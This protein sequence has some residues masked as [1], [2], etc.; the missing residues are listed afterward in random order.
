MAVLR[1]MQWKSKW[2]NKGLFPGRERRGIVA[3]KGEK[4]SCGDKNPLLTL[5]I[6]KVGLLHHILQQPLLL[7]KDTCRS[8]NYII[9]A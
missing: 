2:K 7:G 8:D 9:L 1:F 4:L 6:T 3:P 5:R